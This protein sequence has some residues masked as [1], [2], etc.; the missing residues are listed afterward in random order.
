MAIGRDQSVLALEN[1]ARLAQSGELLRV[2]RL[3]KIVS[4]SHDS[5]FPVLSF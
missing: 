2:H 4:H 1:A 5:R 3:A